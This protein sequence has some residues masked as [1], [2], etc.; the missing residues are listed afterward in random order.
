MNLRYA[1]AGLTL[2][3]VQCIA[4]PGFASGQ[5]ALDSRELSGSEEADVS[6]TSCLAQQIH[7]DV[8]IIRYQLEE[9]RIQGNTQTRDSVIRSFIPLDVGDTLDVDDPLVEVIKFRLVGTGWFESVQ[10]R[11]ARGSR[12]GWVRLI[13]SVVERNTL[14]VRNV[15]LGLAEGLESSRDDSTDLVFYLGTDIAETN[16]LGTGTTVGGATILSTSQ[17][18]GRLYLSRPHLFGSDSSFTASTFFNNAREFFGNNDVMVS[19]ECPP[20]VGGCSSVAR[21]AVVLYRRGGFGF[22]T[23]GDLSAST[24]YFLDWQGEIVQVRAMPDAASEVR[25]I[26]TQ[27]IDFAIE[28]GR[29]FVS[30]LRAGLVFDQRDRPA[31]T[32]RGIY[33]QLVAESGSRVLGS[34]YDFLRIQGWLRGWIPLPGAA[35]MHTLRLGAYAGV[36]FGDAPFFYKFHISNLTDLIP[37]RRLE[38]TLDRRPA[39]NFLGTAIEVMHHGEFVSRVDAEYRIRLHQGRRGLR[40]VDWYTNIG[41]W[42]LA[43]LDDLRVAVPG[44]EGWAK[45]PVDLTFDFGLRLET[46]AGIFQFGFSTLVGF[47]EL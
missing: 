26:E 46:E 6:A 34:N 8:Q 10:L 39:P 30:R 3:T 37:S 32:T 38:M 23:G 24:R 47:T 40:G 27:P 17:Q 4:L 31:L 44:Y 7:P 21:N 41:L 15:T 29:S 36:I 16:F 11:L 42:V 1:F 22:G 14:L 43:E 35:P 33:S 12:R 19:L 13:V 2:S 18:G 25:G 45:V 28:D 5:E 9:V 20:D